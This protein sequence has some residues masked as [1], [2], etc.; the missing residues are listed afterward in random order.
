MKRF[1][2]IGGRHLLIVDEI[3]IFDFKTERFDWVLLRNSPKIHLE[4]LIKTLNPKLIIAD[5]S[6]YKSSVTRWQ[7]T[8]RKNSVRFHNTY[9]Q[10]AFIYSIKK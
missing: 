6:N 4:Q 7:K 3:G 5:G 2:S 10:G 8:C 1:Y 9:E